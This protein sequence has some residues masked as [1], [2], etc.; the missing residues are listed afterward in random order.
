MK[1]FTWYEYRRVWIFPYQIERDNLYVLKYVINND[2]LSVGILLKSL[3]EL[4]VKEV[5]KSRLNRVYQEEI[6]MQIWELTL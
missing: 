5:S 6:L 1:L 3:V 2:R 4:N